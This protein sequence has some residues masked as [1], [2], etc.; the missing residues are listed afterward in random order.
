MNL[1]IDGHA[2]LNVAINVTKSVT[3]KDLRVGQKYWVNNLFEDRDTLKEDARIY[4]RNFV[5]KNFNFLFY[6]DF[7]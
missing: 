5:Y 1:I 6:K 3:E 4:F 7:N 2:F